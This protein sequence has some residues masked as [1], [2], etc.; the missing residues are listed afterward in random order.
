MSAEIIQF[1][2]RPNRRRHLSPS[3]ARARS[4]FAEDDL[5]M[6]HADTATCEYV[7]SCH[8]RGGQDGK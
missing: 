3:S 2:L 6:D 1:V 5:A 7:S 4:I 8:E